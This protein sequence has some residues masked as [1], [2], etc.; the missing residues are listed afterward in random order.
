MSLDNDDYRDITMEEYFTTREEVET[1]IQDN[2]NSEISEFDK[3]S[4][5]NKIRVLSCINLV[6]ENACL[7]EPSITSDVIELVNKT[8]GKLIPLNNTIKGKNSL[9]RKIIADSVNYNYEIAARKIRDSVRYTIIIED[10]I[11]VE[12]V[13]DY[14]HKLEEMGYQNIVV[15]N[16]WGTLKCQGIN[17]KI[18]TKDGKNV[19]EIQFHTPFGYQIKE[20][21]TR[22]LYKIFRDHSAPADLKTKV[23]KLRKLLQS[24]V[25]APENALE[26]NFVSSVKRR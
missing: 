26:Y 7:I 6:Y 4:D 14:L 15:K 1:Y 19:F 25:K 18:T 13:D 8:E 22:D 17:T 16:N 9:K 3:L 10:D 11:Y 20:M 12:K 2:P 23:V 24:G 21:C 5:E